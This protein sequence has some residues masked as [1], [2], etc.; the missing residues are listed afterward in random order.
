MVGAGFTHPIEECHGLVGA[1]R[2]HLPEEGVQTLALTVGAL[3]YH[4]SLASIDPAIGRPAKAVEEDR[5]LG[6]VS[7]VPSARTPDDILDILAPHGA[8][9]IVALLDDELIRACA[10][11][12]SVDPGRIRFRPGSP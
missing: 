10:T 5:T 6:S 8:A 7:V 4:P 9:L 1:A 2:L 11:G 12:Q 3:H